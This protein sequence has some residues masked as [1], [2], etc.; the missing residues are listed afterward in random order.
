[1]MV[2]GPSRPPGAGGHWRFIQHLYFHPASR[3]MQNPALK[4]VVVGTGGTIAGASTDA[5]DNIGYRAAERGVADLVRGVPALADVPLEIEQVAQLDSKDMDHAV[6]RAIALRCAFHLARPDV[7]GLVIT[8]GTDTLEETAWFLQRV[9]APAKP[10]VLT[11]A[12]RPATALHSDGPQNL[13]DAVGVARAEGAHGVVAVLGGQV[14]GARDVRK[15][16]PYRIDAFSAGDAGPVGVIE[17]GRLRLFRAWPQD[18]DALEVAGLPDATA[19]W[20]FVAIV[21]SHAGA[22]GA[23]VSALRAAGVRGLVVAATGNGSVH[24]ELE[25]ALLEAQRDGVQV[26]R[27]TRCGDG[28]V[29]DAEAPALPSADDLTPAKARVELMLRLMTTR[30]N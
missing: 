16:H 4:V 21:T 17:E 5:S 18:G 29:L 1:M 25:H 3:K 26:L 15:V 24:R 9:L 12:M 28:R 2:G 10:V 13:L 30:A 7:A 14:F 8:H 23:V 6:W 27:S 20:P 22:S 19:T 11:A